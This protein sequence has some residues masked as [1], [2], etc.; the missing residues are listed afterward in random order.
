MKTEFLNYFKDFIEGKD[1][2]TWK[3]FW[4][5]NSKELEKDLSRTEFLKLKFDNISFAQEILK[6]HHISYNWTAKGKQQKAWANLHDSVCDENGKPLL[7]FR[8]KLFS[9]AFGFYLDN[10]IEETK[11]K[12][13]KHIAVIL[14]EK[15]TLD[16]ADRLNDA[17]FDAEALIDEGF[18]EFGIIVLQEISKIMTDNDLLIPAVNY[19]KS[20]LEKEL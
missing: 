8:R 7:S 18:T 20:R 10:N 1:V 17:E 13:K 15:N 2:I 6:K 12:V 3:S 5:E 9:G 11:I 19:A 16:K 4:K 14:K